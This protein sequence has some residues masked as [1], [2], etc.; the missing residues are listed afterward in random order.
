M[1]YVF[2]KLNYGFSISPRECS[3]SKRVPSNDQ[4]FKYSLSIQKIFQ[5][6]TKVPILEVRLRLKFN[7]VYLY[8]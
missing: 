6:E 4:L 8:T 7:F 3:I 1:T 2:V 5:T